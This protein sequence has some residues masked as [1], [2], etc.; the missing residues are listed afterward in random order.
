MIVIQ[1]HSLCW[2]WYTEQTVV[3]SAAYC[4]SVA[5]LCSWDGALSR[6]ILRYWIASIDKNG[7]LAREQIL[8]EEARSRVPQ[9]IQP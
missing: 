4:V 9:V 7:W 3:C 2:C 8:G 1:R 5:F 6:N